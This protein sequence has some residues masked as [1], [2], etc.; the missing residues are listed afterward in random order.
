MQARQ[1]IPMVNRSYTLSGEPAL[2]ADRGFTGH[3]FLSDFNLYNMNGRLYDPVVG[4]F[5]SPDPYIADPSFTQS[6]NRYSYVLNNPLKYNDP[7]G[8]FPWLAAGIF[9]AYMYLNNAYANRDQST[10]KWAWNPTS[11]FG[12][13]SNTTVQ[14]G[15]KTN[16]DFSDVTA[17]MG[18]GVGSS[19]PAF[20]VNTNSGVGFGVNTPQGTDIVY[21]GAKQP[22]EQS[23]ANEAIGQA[24][25][26][27]GSNT[28]SDL[29]YW[30]LALARAKLNAPADAYS[31]AG[32]ID[33]VGGLGADMSFPGRLR[34]NRGNDRGKSTNIFD[35]GIAAGV[36][37]GASVVMTSY[38][39]VGDI[40][41][42]RIVDLSGTRTAGSFGLSCGLEIGGG[43]MIAR[44]EHGYIIGKSLHIGF[45][46]PGVSGNVNRGKTFFY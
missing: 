35:F 39:F 6:Y 26:G 9:A 42:F 4:R 32:N 19:I 22:S 7:T 43:F 8:E 45:S 15:V 2:F 25:K 40:N 34:V 33:I 24:R 12:K 44:V 46:P 11:W 29:F 14:F 5:L 41:D 1:Q 27:Y 20:A 21:P 23:I 13:G 38:Y 30:T 10:G 3:E 18:I 31:V 37:V 36:D 16:S 28:S 17:F